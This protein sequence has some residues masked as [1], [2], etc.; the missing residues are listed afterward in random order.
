MKNR[1]RDRRP[2]RSRPAKRGEV[3]INEA[4]SSYEKWMRGCSTV[5]A[6]DLRSKHEQM[7]E[8]PFLFLRG[9]FYRWAQLWPSV[10]ADLCNAPQVLA[11]ADLHVNS[12]G[13]WRGC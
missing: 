7:M 2:A 1:K 5:I 12:F 10:R 3:D 9:T 4:T 13:T 11:V 6:S 8:S